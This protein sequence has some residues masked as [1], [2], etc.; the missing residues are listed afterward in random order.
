[1]PKYFKPAPKREPDPNQ[2]PSRKLSLQEMNS[3]IEWI[4]RHKKLCSPK[5]IKNLR[6]ASRRMEKGFDELGMTYHAQNNPL[7]T[8]HIDKSISPELATLFKLTWG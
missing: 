3:A 1:M 8:L 4:V 5:F 7:I 2:V 6:R